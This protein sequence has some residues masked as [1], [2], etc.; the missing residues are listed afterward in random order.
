MIDMLFARGKG[1]KRTTGVPPPTLRLPEDRAP[2]LPDADDD[3]VFAFSAKKLSKALE[4]RL[5]IVGDGDEG[6]VDCGDGVRSFH[7]VC[8]PFGILFQ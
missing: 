3:G 8:E 7:M 4:N 2:S 6:D 1:I 5:S